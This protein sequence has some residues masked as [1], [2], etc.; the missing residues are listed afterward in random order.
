M[1]FNFYPYDYVEKNCSTAVYELKAFDT[2]PSVLA[3]S[4]TDFL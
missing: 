2:S 4:I 3:G 1:F